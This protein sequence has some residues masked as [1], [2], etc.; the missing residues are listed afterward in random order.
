MSDAENEI[1]CY[2]EAVLQLLFGRLRGTAGPMWGPGLGRARP[3]LSRARPGLAVD[4]RGFTKTF[5]LARRALL[6]AVLWAV[7]LPFLDF[8]R[9]KPWHVFT[10]F[11]FLAVG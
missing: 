10:A 3:E 7:L 4:G 11:Q 6:S 2:F 1:C 5:M 8:F 9:F